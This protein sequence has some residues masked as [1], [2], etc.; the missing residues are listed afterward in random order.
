M[1][2]GVETDLNPGYFLFGR[3]HFHE[4]FKLNSKSINI[5]DVYTYILGLTGFFTL[6]LCFDFKTDLYE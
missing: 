6:S 4:G 2:K 1:L 3:L 5:K